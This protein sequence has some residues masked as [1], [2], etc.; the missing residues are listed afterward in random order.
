MT[1]PYNC[2]DCVFEAMA[3]TNSGPFLEVVKRL[4]PDRVQWDSDNATI[5]T[6]GITT[7]SCWRMIGANENISVAEMENLYS[8]I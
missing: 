5:G 3:N 8:T 6:S 2:P 4:G 7:T 1:N